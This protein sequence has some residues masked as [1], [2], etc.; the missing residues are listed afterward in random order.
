MPHGGAQARRVRRRSALSC[1]FEALANRD[2]V[3][4]TNFTHVVGTKCDE[5]LRSARSRDEFNADRVWGTD[6]NDGAEIAAPQSMH[7]HF[8]SEHDDHERVQGPLSSLR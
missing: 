3:V 4:V 7:R 5:G 1:P 8:I 6:L 2:Q